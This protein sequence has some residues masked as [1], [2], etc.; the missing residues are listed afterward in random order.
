MSLIVAAVRESAPGEA[1]VALVPEVVAP[2]KALGLD[3]LVQ[4]GAGLRAHISD[5]AYA[6]AGASAVTAAELYER[7][8][9]VLCVTPPEDAR[10]RRGQVL[11]GL[12]EPA[13]HPERLEKWTA[14]GITAISLDR[15]PRTLSRAQSMDVLSSQAS[16]AGYKAA[17]EAANAYGGYLPMLTTAAGTV[18]PATVLVLGAGVAGLQAIATARRLGAVVTGYDVRPETRSEITSLGARFLELGDGIEASGSGGYARELT[19]AERE[20]QQAALDARIAGFDIVITAAAVPGRRPPLLVGERALNAMRPGSVV[21]DTASGPL[22][23]NVA[24][25]KPDETVTVADGVTVI[26]AGD[27]AARV[28]IAASTAYARNLKAVLASFVRD[29][30]FAVDPEDEVHAAIVL[31]QGESK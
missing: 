17:L 29:G 15:I 7:A 25:S 1:R 9:I 28:P 2:L 24:L 12:L 18:K 3:V 27:L 26:G 19:E 23:G 14:D 31:T 6:A 16:V 11:I 20:T 30:A 13:R 22:G 4:A 10:L 8:D 5:D 21:L